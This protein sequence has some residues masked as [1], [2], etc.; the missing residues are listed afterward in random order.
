MNDTTPDAAEVQRRVLRSMSTARK[1]RL[2]GELCDTARS[3]SMVGIRS[4]HPAYSE[5]EVRWA[6]W[7][8]LHGDEL[9][10]R[11]WPHAPLLP[12]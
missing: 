6:L 11:A 12:P 8:M 10:R 4:R 1:A 9:F 7:R 2:I 5:Q 3:L